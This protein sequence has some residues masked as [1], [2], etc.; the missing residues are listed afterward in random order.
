[1]R[2]AVEGHL[3]RW[4]TPAAVS[5]GFLPWTPPASTL[6]LPE[7]PA[8]T[9]E[10]ISPADSVVHDVTSSTGSTSLDPDEI[11]ERPPPPA[12][13]PPAEP[14]ESLCCSFRHSGWRDIRRRVYAG[15]VAAGVPASRLDRFAKCGSSAWVEMGRR[16]DYVA[17]RGATAPIDRYRV[18]CNTCRDRFCVPCA[19]TRARIVAHT[20]IDL[21]GDEPARFITLTVKHTDAPLR[22]QVD[23]LYRSY[24]KLRKTV[25]WQRHVFAAAALLEIK[26]GRDD[27]LWHPHLHVL[28][29]GR[30]VPHADLKNEWHRITEDSFIV[31]IRIIKDPAR[32]AAY[33]SKYVT[34]PMVQTYSTDTDAVAEAVQAMHHRRTVLLTG[35]WRN[36]HWEKQTDDHTWEWVGNLDSLVHRALAGEPAALQVMDRLRSDGKWRP[37]AIARSP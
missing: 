11:P 5:E 15:L 4:F 13:A 10:P 36:L 12:L 17:G 23:R 28:T 8:R 22:Q 20:L 26:R 1:M 9:Q 37:T 30:F 14:S 25:L 21:L 31:D 2:T 32:A 7:P 24:K 19:G 27:R 29:K 16:K 33:V 35:D 34:K 6:P 3:R 18:R